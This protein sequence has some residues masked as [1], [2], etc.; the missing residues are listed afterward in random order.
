VRLSTLTFKLFIGCLVFAI[1]LE[2]GLSFLPVATAFER[3]EQAFPIRH[4]KPYSNY[5]YSNGW[6]FRNPQSGRVNNY[7]FVNVMDYQAGKA[8]VLVIGDS[9][10]E[11]QQVP[12]EMTLH[13]VNQSITGLATYAIG[14]NDSHFAD[15]VRYMEYGVKEYAPEFVVVKL[16][17]SDLYKAFSNPK[18]QGSY[19]QLDNEQATLVT[20][21]INLNS[22]KLRNQLKKSNVL[23]YL[24]LNLML[25]KKAIAAMK[26]IIKPAKAD[27]TELAVKQ[28]PY[29]AVFSLFEQKLKQL[30][31]NK[32]NVIFITDSEFVS[33]SVAE[34]GY[35][36]VNSQHILQQF[37][38]ETGF[39]GNNLPYDGHWNFRGHYL[40]GSQV[41]ETIGAISGSTPFSL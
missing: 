3:D 8:D 29:Q 21:K 6:N 16:F 1:A 36:S 10:I 41:A 34:M 4:W 25:P 15:Y 18:P 26:S 13:A 35:K 11:A 23:R 32:K 12:Q 28:F 27:D 17:D 14:I 7:G 33:Q 38:Q 39:Q 40:V 30:S 37:Q 9:Y 5:T 24:F 31:V 20:N 19:F 2:V 22:G